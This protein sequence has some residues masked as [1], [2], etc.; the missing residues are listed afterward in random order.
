MAL[1]FAV[2]RLEQGPDGLGSARFA[3]LVAAPALE[4][5]LRYPGHPWFVPTVVAAPQDV[6]PMARALAT[7][8]VEEHL[9]TLRTLRRADLLVRNPSDL[10]VRLEE[11]E[12]LSWSDLSVQDRAACPALLVL[13]GPEAGEPADAS[14]LGPLLRQDL[15]IR[16]LLL[17]G[18]DAPG[19]GPDP[20]LLAVASGAS[21]VGSTSPAFPEHLGTTLR[22]AFSAKGPSLVVLHAPSPERLGFPSDQTLE[23][24]RKAV[25]ARVAPLFRFDPTGATLHERFDLS[26]NPE[27]TDADA[28]DAWLRDQ[29]LLSERLDPAEQALAKR[30]VLA[31]WDGLQA[32]AGPPTVVA[33]APA[34][35]PPA[36]VVDRSDIEQELRLRLATNLRRLAHPRG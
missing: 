3:A 34:P 9:A 29:R 2:E 16:I 13:V 10:R 18:Q 33:V 23:V 17:D 12:G 19:A 30:A 28:F 8:L 7:S 22:A 4:P 6:V 24:A 21:W 27:Q 11:L 32:L 25:A 5:L 35:P 14:G 36:P 31:R 15:P 26:G 1:R 20:A